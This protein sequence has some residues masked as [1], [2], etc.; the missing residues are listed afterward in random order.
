[1]NNQDIKNN[2]ILSISTTAFKKAMSAISNDPME[3]AMALGLVG[4]DRN[5]PGKT[6]AIVKATE[7]NLKKNIADS[8]FQNLNNETKNT[9]QIVSQKL[10]K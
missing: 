9:I 4:L 5:L 1:M 3:V 7:N 10:Q 2:N 6:D 8:L